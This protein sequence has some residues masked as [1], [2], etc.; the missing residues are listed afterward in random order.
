[1]RAMPEWLY[2]LIPPRPTFADDAT[3]F[4]A[5]KM[6]EHF[7]YLQRLAA[8]GTL[9]LA[10]RTQD[11]PPTGIAIFRAPDEGV[12]RAIMSGDP[13]IAA[14]VVRGELHPYAVALP[15]SS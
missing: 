15:R 7:A 13:A 12:A 3:D 10:G 9:I 11:Q 14:G 5:A 6:R 1:M 8:E 4:E 2:F